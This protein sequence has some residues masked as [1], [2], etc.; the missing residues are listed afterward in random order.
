M[1]FGTIFTLDT[2]AEAH[3]ATAAEIGEDALWANLDG[4]FRA[5][6]ELFNQAAEIIGERT[7]DRQ[8]RFGGTGSVIMQELDEYGQP[9]AQKLAI[10][11][12]NVGFPLR[13]W[14]AAIQ[15]TRFAFENMSAD[16]F[17]RQ[18]NAI[19]DADEQNLY[20]QIR[21]AIYKP[22]NSTFTDVQQMPSIDLAVKALVNADSQPIPTGP[23]GTA[24]DG[25]T[26]THYL[27]ITTANTP[28]QANYVALIEHVVEHFNTGSPVVYI[29]RADESK[30][31]G[32][33]DFTE[34]VDARLIDQTAG[35][36]ARATLDTRNLYDR[37]IGLLSGAEVWVKPWIPAG[38]PLAFVRGVEP[39]VVLRQPVPAGAQ[40][41]R[42]V[43]QDENHPLRASE[44]EHR[45]GVAVWN[46]LN[47]AV[48]DT[49][50]GSATYSMPS[51]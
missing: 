25:A 39:P 9:S 31:R 41:L 15:W 48:L 26:H 16:E 38:Y 28:T 11:G 8:R 13:R 3:K 21:R 12:Y 6:T 44:W 24:F 14:G 20:A 45:Y 51:V 30:V 37:A 4:Y 36:V 5:H 27:G 23:S 46:R 2:V 17:Q 35:V 50:T 42:L 33:A 34:Y 19:A 32:F 1:A 7:T 22:T 10:P 29:N 18:V 47:G 40:S 43:A 49:V